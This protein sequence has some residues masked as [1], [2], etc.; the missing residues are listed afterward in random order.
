LI[1]GKWVDWLKRM[2]FRTAINYER[3]YAIEPS[4]GIRRHTMC[5]ELDEEY[6]R[7]SKSDSAKAKIKEFEKRKEDLK[8]F[9]AS[10]FDGLIYIGTVIRVIWGVASSVSLII[11]IVS[12]VNGA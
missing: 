1:L 8:Y 4:L 7:L 9:K 2:R 3:M 6:K 11:L 5:K 12:L 10:G